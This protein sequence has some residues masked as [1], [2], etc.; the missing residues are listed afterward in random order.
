MYRLSARINSILSIF[1]SLRSLH[2]EL[3]FPQ[4]ASI[5]TSPTTTGVHPVWFVS[6]CF[7]RRLLHSSVSHRNQPTSTTQVF[8]SRF[9]S[10]TNLS[11]HHLTVH[12]NALSL[13]H[14]QSAV[15]LSFRTLLF[16]SLSPKPSELSLSH[17]PCLAPRRLPLSLS[18]V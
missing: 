2:F 1:L 8:I 15:S 6:V 16:G 17:K 10:Y 9:N 3:W 5:F 4:K 11:F 18:V 13:A 14:F 12:I 7:T